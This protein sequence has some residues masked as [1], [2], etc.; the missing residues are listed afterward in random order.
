MK[1]ALACAAA[2]GLSALV[3]SG[4]AHAATAGFV[5]S[6]V[7]TRFQADTVATGL[8]SF[9]TDAGGTLTAFL[10]DLTLTSPTVNLGSPGT[11]AFHYVLADVQPG[12]LSTF[13]SGAL[14]ALSFSTNSRP[15]SFYPNQTFTVEGL[16]TNAAS[17]GNP[18]AGLITVGTVTSSSVPEPGTIALLLTG[19]VGLAL[20]RRQGSPARS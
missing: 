17:S 7:G 18:D 15:G 10:F 12:F 11:D 2:L 14:T 5:Y 19:L 9:T 1:S 3:S 6:G 4:G 8:G 16:Q 20:L 13:T